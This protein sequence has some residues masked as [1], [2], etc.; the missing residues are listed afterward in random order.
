MSMPFYVEINS[1]FM[2]NLYVKCFYAKTSRLFEKK[3]IIKFSVGIE[4]NLDA[5]T[6]DRK[7]LFVKTL[8]MKYVCLTQKSESGQMVCYTK[9]I[10][11]EIES[12]IFCP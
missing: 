10:R 3:S 6:K 5:I 4:Y 7:L 8:L 11:K 12:F 9:M 2:S 1:Y